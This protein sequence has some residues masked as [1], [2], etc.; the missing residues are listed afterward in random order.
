MANKESRAEGVKSNALWAFVKAR[1]AFITSEYIFKIKQLFWIGFIRVFEYPV[2]DY[3]LM[4]IYITSS[5][6]CG[7]NEFTGLRLGGVRLA[8]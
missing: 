3:Q 8:A 2:K 1:L 5:P 4:R 7:G 6:N